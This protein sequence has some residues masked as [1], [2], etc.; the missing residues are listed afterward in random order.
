[1]GNLR[2]K[3]TSV[4]HLSRF[5]A[6]EECDYKEICPLCARSIALQTPKTCHMHLDRAQCLLCRS[7]A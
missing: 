7:K 4:V 3:S 1:M 2:V 5:S 6:P